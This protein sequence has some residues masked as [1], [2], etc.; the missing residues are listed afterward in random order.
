LKDECHAKTVR[1]ECIVE[2]PRDL[3]VRGGGPAGVGAA[4]AA[5]R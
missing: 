4:L 1:P 2:S 5:A 3:D